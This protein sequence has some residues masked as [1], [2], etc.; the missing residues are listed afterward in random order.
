[1][2]KKAY[3]AWYGNPRACLGYFATHEDAISALGY[4]CLEGTIWGVEGYVTEEVNLPKD[5]PITP[6]SAHKKAQDALCTPTERE[7]KPDE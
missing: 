6:L 4:V 3:S 7:V 5:I 2:S 1:M